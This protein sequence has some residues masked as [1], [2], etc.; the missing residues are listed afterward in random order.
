MLIEGATGE[1]ES[2][3]LFG[4][5]L[6]LLRLL[7]DTVVFIKTLLDFSAMAG[8]FFAG[9]SGMSSQRYAKPSFP[10]PGVEFHANL[11]V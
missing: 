6:E 1:T 5:V 9:G 7:D 3:L 11:V 8:V 4:L 2:E 10:S